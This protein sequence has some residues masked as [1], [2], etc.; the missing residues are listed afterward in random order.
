MS[1]S[2]REWQA[3]DDFRSLVSAQEVTTDKRRFSR[4][5]RAG[6]RIVRKE[7]RTLGLKR[8]ISRG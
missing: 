2:D 6:R 8:R 7:T 4:A 5:R 3:E 1:K